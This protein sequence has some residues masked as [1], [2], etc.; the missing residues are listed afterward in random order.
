[1]GTTAALLEAGAQKNHQKDVRGVEGEGVARSGCI[2]SLRVVGVNTRYYDGVKLG[3]RSSIVSTRP[4]HK[5]GFFPGFARAGTDESPFISDWIDGAAFG[6]IQR[7]CGGGGDPAGCG[8]GQA[9]PKAGQHVR[10]VC[11]Q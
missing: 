7:P 11:A 2:E 5:L 8:R 4:A 9:D 1:M 6:S 3:R 10:S